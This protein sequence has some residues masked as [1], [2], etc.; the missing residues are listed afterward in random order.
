MITRRD[1]QPQRQML[2]I[3]AGAGPADSVN[4]QLRRQHPH[5]RRPDQG[6]DHHSHL[7]GAAEADRILARGQRRGHL[8]DQPVARSGQENLGMVSS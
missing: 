4:G 3:L 2:D 6:R 1:L 7:P 5:Q 8:R